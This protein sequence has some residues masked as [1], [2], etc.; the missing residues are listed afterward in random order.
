MRMPV[1]HAPF[2][3]RWRL[4]HREEWDQD[5]LDLVEQT[6]IEFDD[7]AQRSFVFEVVK[8][9]LDCRFNNYEDQ[10]KVKFSW[11]GES[12]FDSVCGIGWPEIDNER[13]I[14]GLLLYS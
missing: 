13:E 5:Y 9:W 14:S 12:E 6:Y 11:E 7:N 8:G 4:V 1:N 2:V 10:P 3:S